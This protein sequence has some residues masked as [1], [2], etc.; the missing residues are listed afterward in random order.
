MIFFKDCVKSS[1]RLRK[2]VLNAKK[3]F[4]IFLKITKPYYK[5]KKG[6]NIHITFNEN[7][8][9]HRNIWKNGK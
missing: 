7:I 8:S 1:F 2:N 3:Y 4:T 5:I 6:D 9:I